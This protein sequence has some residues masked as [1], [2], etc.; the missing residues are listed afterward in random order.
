MLDAAKQK[1]NQSSAHLQPPSRPSLALFSRPLSLPSPPLHSSHPLRLP[2][3]LPSSFSSSPS[4]RLPTPSLRLPALM[5]CLRKQGEFS[6]EMQTL[7]PRSSSPVQLRTVSPRAPTTNRNHTTTTNTTKT[8][9]VTHESCFF[10]Q[11]NLSTQLTRALSLLMRSHHVSRREPC[12][13]TAAAFLWRILSSDW[14]SHASWHVLVP[15]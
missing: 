3:R 1:D 15:M 2:F 9:R 12:F 4:L 5:T 6:L 7:N 11:N 8:Q 10:C 13:R 14:S